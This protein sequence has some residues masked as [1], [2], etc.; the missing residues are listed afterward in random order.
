MT[1][2]KQKRLSNSKKVTLSFLGVIAIGTILLMLPIAHNDNQFMSLIDA[3]FTATSATCVTG[4]GVVVTIDSFS[5]FGQIVILL[6]IQIGGIGLMT[7]VATF[8]SVMKAKIKLIDKMAL[9]TVLSKSDLFDFKTFLMAIFKYTLFFEG[10]GALIL[11]FVMIPEYGLASGIFKSIFLS[12]SAFCNAGFDVIGAASL[13][14]FAHQP[15]VTITIMSLIVF[16]GIGF[17]VWFELSNKLKSYIQNK[18]SFKQF[19]HSLSLHTKLVVIATLILIFAPALIFFI[20]E[21]NSSMADLNLGNKI[22]NSLFMSITLRTAGFATVNTIDMHA[23]SQLIMVI[24]MFIGGSPGGTAGGVKTTTMMVIVVCVIRMLRGKERTNIFKRHISRN[25]IVRA[26]T[27]IMLNIATL[28]IGVFLLCIIEPFDI[29]T[30]VFEGVSALATVGLSL[31]ITPLLS[32]AGKFIII[33][34]MFIGRIGITTFIVSIIKDGVN[35]KNIQY[36]EGH[37][38]V[39]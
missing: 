35:E 22:L 7:L 4:L 17:I 14:P 38:I 10:I 36:A 16:G 8:M 11:A 25:I 29:F 37:V 6:L 23:A 3:L 19:V 27:I 26:T 21:Y 30:L 2:K 39:G 13:I 1:S 24:A 34:L 9:K 15:I 28:I 31:G 5:L 18:V 20:L 33:L 32:S 12:V